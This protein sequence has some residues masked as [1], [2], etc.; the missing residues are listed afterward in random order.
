LQPLNQKS[1]KKYA[2]IPILAL[3]AQYNHRKDSQQNP[4]QSP[5]NTRTVVTEKHN[6]KKFA[7]SGN[8]ALFKNALTVRCQVTGWRRIENP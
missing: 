6:H 4:K 1:R 8:F 2:K 5:P 7:P 3:Y